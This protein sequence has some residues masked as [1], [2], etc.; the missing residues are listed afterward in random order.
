[1]SAPVHIVEALELVVSLETEAYASIGSVTRVSPSDIV[2]D[3]LTQWLKAWISKH[4][5]LPYSPEERG[6]YVARLAE[7][8]RGEL[9]S[10]L[11]T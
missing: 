7:T 8:F 6:E 4:G 2:S 11:D 5:S 9:R 1:M 10:E 3:A